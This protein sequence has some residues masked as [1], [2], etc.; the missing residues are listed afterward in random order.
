M[1]ISFQF[2][3]KRPLRICN[4]FYVGLTPLS[5]F[6]FNNVSNKC[7]I[8]IVGHPLLPQGGDKVAAQQL[9]KVAMMYVVSGNVRISGKCELFMKN[10]QKAVMV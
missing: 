3:A 6:F 5:F 8:G 7:Q 10:G 4:F 2:Y 9:V 1:S